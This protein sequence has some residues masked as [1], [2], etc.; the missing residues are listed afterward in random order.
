MHQ[1]VVRHDGFTEE[2]VADRHGGGFGVR[3]LY[4]AAGKTL[5]DEVCRIRMG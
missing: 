3:N 5:C 4:R 1:A 2:P